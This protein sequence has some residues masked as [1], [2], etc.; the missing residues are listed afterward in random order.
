MPGEGSLWGLKLLIMMSLR[1]IFSGGA[2][3]KFVSEDLKGGG[4]VRKD[5]RLIGFDRKE[6]E[7][8]GGRD[9]GVVNS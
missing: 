7:L 4:G 2:F 6:F 8:P 3:L 1:L 9:A 5:E